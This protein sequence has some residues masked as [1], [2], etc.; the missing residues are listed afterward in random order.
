MG[1]KR[2]AVVYSCCSVAQWGYTTELCWVCGI[3]KGR[4]AWQETSHTDYDG[5]QTRKII[6]CKDKPKSMI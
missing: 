3:A 5:M 6:D 2:A 4:D 1:H